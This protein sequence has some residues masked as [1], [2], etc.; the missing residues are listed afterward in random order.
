MAVDPFR[1]GQ[2]GLIVAVPEAEAA[3]GEFRR[4]YDHAAAYGVPAHLTVLFPFLP[5]DRIDRD[6]HTE[7][8]NLLGAL[9]PFDVRFER[10]DRFPDVLFLAPEPEEPLRE[11][12]SSVAA[13]WSEYQPYGGQ[14]ADVVPHLTVAQ[15]DDQRV[16]DD[17]ECSVAARLPI[18][19]TVT[20]V[21]LISFDGNRW[22]SWHEFRLG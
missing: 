21:R 5:V 9:E 11:L 3:V 14:F 16:L 10:T 8:A 12:T 4:S 2:T 6:V 20:G 1:P 15:S 17:I 7:L 19:A 13:R 22:N 18:A